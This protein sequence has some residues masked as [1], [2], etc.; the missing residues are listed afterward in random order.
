MADAPGK[1]DSK[2][3]ATWS[4]TELESELAR[5]RVARTK[6]TGPLSSG[7]GATSGGRVERALAAIEKD[8]EIAQA[9]ANL[10]LGKG[11]SIEDVEKKYSELSAK[12]A[13]EKQSDASRAELAKEL[14]AQ[15]AKA[16][17]RLRQYLSAR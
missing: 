17:E 13:P 11:A 4:D 3:L 16:Y 12:Y 8:R 2:T 7:E 1:L 5:R 14:R 6:K 15:L 10:E 9:Y